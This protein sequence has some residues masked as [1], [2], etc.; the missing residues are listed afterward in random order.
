MKNGLAA[1]VL[2]Q[3]TGFQRHAPRLTITLRGSKKNFLQFGEPFRKIGEDF[4]GDF[5]LVAS[6][7]EDAR[8]Q[9]PSW[10]IRVQRR[11]EDSDAKAPAA[12]ADMQARVLVFKNLECKPL[13]QFHP[14]RAEKRAYR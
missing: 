12:Q 3:P 1:M 4:R 9:N 2:A 5:A 14:G 7:T 8:H 13:L 11:F 10:G 6:R